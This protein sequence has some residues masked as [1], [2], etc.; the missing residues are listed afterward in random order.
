MD[1]SVASVFGELLGDSRRA[2]R[3]E[4]TGELVTLEEQNRSLLA[5]EASEQLRAHR[6]ISQELH[7]VSL[8]G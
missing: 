7:H 6:Q 1:T 3:I 8:S 4:T 2:A 5:A